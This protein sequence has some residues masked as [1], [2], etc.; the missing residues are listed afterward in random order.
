MNTENKKL[1]VGVF[2]GSKSPEHDVSIASAYAV[3]LGLERSKK[4]NVFPIYITKS[5]KWLYSEKF[6]DIKSFENVDSI[7]KNYIANSDCQLNENKSVIEFKKGFGTGRIKLDIAF[8]VFHGLNG[9]DGTFQGLFE[10]VNLPYCSSGILGS[11]LGID[12]IAM[13]SFF[14]AHDIPIVRYEAFSK[15]DFEKNRDDVISSIEKS[16]KY[17]MFVKPSRLGSSIGVSRVENREEL[18]NGIEV[19]IHF[20]K[21]FVV[22]ESVKNLKEINC[23]VRRINGKIEAS[24]TEEIVSNKNFLTFEEKYIDSGGTMAG[25]KNKVKAPADVPLE[26]NDEIRRLAIKIFEVFECGG[27][28]RIDFLFDSKAGKLYVNEINTIPGAL[29][30]HLWKASGVEFVDLLDGMVGDALWVHENK[31]SIS[32]TFKSEIVAKTIAFKK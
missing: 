18:I 13:K 2:F 15:T 20:D 32:Y 22:E 12:K 10:V 23:S 26:I 7:E 21:A 11:I 19:A 24:L 1:N 8:P 16:I 9:E 6:K 27:V 25:V 14:R 17:P 4:Y 28:P 31:N 5:G 29:Q 3:M 30:A